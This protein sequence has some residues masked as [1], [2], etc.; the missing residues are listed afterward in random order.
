MTI[1]NQVPELA[2]SLER[3]IH[4]A[5]RQGDIRELIESASA[6]MDRLEAAAAD[7][8]STLTEE[9]V[10]ALNTAR[11]IGYNAA[12]DIWPGWQVGTPARSESE[13]QAG[14]TLARRS[15]AI[16]ERLGKGAVAQGTA[17]WLIGAF[18]L[19]RGRRKEA[20]AAFGAAAA[21]YAD[22]PELKLLSEG[23]MAIAS[24]LTSASSTD[25]TP[26]FAS[27]IAELGNLPSEDAKEFRN[28]LQVA[29]QVFNFQ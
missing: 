4:E 28:Q 20:W 10:I 14:Q 1:E 26:E 6:A 25:A 8:G 22:A 3:E 2:R 9:Q 29:R 12:A 23:Y 18:D 21:F 19:A 17:V 5:R 13:L 7:T 16:V 11:R 15:S 27:V 24:E